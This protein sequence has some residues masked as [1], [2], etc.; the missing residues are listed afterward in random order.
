[1]PAA[2][3]DSAHPM[4]PPA[5][6]SSILAA[7]LRRCASLGWRV[8]VTSPA[9]THLFTR[10]IA[11][12]WERRL[13]PVQ[14]AQWAAAYRAFNGGRERAY[15][16]ASWRILA[17]DS[18]RRVVGAITARFFCG[19]VVQEH[20]YLA[21]LLEGTGVVFRDACE[22][23][24]AEQFAAAQG[25]G[26]MPAEIS[27]WSVEGGEHARLLALTLS[28]AMLALAAAFDHPLTVLAANHRRPEFRRLM[29]W[30]AIPLGRGGHYY[31]PP[32]LH[33]TSGASY[34]LMVIDSAKLGART[35]ESVADLEVLRASCPIISLP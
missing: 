21:H 34:R 14:H 18:D 11:R 32:F 20:L 16:R 31:L 4:P 26:R 3:I 22:V 9:E 35:Q 13:D 8:V 19:E 2:T 25:V 12:F 17:V 28:R 15:D 33:R 6:G 23:A 24:L 29:R 7:C 30:G 27:H 1:M 5:E 10:S